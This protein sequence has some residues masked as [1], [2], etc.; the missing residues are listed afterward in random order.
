MKLIQFRHKKKLKY[1]SASERKHLVTSIPVDVET[2]YTF[3]LL[4]GHK[5]QMLEVDAKQLREYTNRHINGNLAI[6]NTKSR[7]PLYPILYWYALHNCDVG[8]YIYIY[9]ESESDIPLELDYFKTSFS[10]IENNKG[11]RKY[12]KVSRLI[13]EASVGLDEWTFGIPVGP[14]DSSMLNTLV[15]RIMKLG[16]P[17][18]EIIL[19]GTPGK[20]FRYHDNVSIVGENIPAPPVHITLKKNILAKSAK[21]KNLCILHDRVLLP[22]NFYE[23]V[24]KFDD[25]FPFYAFHSVYSF[26]KLGMINIRYSDYNCSNKEDF[27]CI[28]HQENEITEHYKR[29]NYFYANSKRYSINNYLTGSL[30]ICKTELWNAVMQD[31]RLFWAEYEDVE[32]GERCNKLGIPHIIN[33]HSISLSLRARSILLGYSSILFES[34]DGKKTRSRINPAAFKI[35]PQRCISEV[36]I[37]EVSNKYIDFLNMYNI[38]VDIKNL[39]RPINRFIVISEIISKIRIIRTESFASKLYSDICKHLIL[40]QELDSEKDKF[41]NFICSNMSDHD[42]KFALLEC[43]SP[44]KNQLYL[45]TL[46]KYFKEKNADSKFWINKVFLRLSTYMIRNNT[47]IHID[48]S[49]KR[50][51]N[52]IRNFMGDIN[53]S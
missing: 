16:I 15:S 6:V 36:S 28:E 24:K 38:H 23:A 10:L 32:F 4:T 41:I 31:E 25:H 34:I 42:I 18:Y 7:T 46:T 27:S 37:N 22:E 8:N 3:D 44:L 29:L 35:L 39:N 9:E 48:I 26:D 33:P 13:V 19:C 52:V 21:Y 20:N 1:R 12:Q 49:K 51:A 5:D 45:S 40:E 30:Y 11:W 53:G 17:K 47:S 43:I 2:V 14:G 50:L